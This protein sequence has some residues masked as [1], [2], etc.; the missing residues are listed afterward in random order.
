[1]IAASSDYVPALRDARVTGVRE[2]MHMVLADVEDTDA[3]P[4]V[5]NL[6]S[7]G[8]VEVFAGKVVHAMWAGPE[9]GRLLDGGS[10][11]APGSRS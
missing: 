5:V 4:S 3:R 6:V 9:V 1:M 8:Y 7:P 10:P 2:G 11:S